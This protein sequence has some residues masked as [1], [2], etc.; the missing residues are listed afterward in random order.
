MVLREATSKAGTARM[1]K[2]TPAGRRRLAKLAA[3]ARWSRS[4][5]SRKR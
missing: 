4:K 1:Q 5:K 2:L 3:K